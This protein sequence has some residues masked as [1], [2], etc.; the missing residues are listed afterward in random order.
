MTGGDRVSG[1]A[2]NE[3]DPIVTVLHA[4]GPTRITATPGRPLRDVL[5][6]AGLSPYARVTERLNCG[7]HGLCATCGVRL[8]D[9]VDHEPEHWH[10]GLARRFGYPR[11]SCQITVDRDMTVRLV[12]DK[13]VWGDREPTK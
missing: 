9:P 4:D 10:D 1:S 13:R 8:V 7:G 6:E 12:E 2:A 11:L 3:S 5:L